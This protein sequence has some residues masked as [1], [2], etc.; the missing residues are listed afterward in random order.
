ME[1]PSFRRPGRMDHV[2]VSVRSGW[3]EKR[4]DSSISMI[5]FHSETRLRLDAVS[6]ITSAVAVDPITAIIMVKTCFHPSSRQTS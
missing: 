2:S 3:R 1:V 6:G 4:G 5:M